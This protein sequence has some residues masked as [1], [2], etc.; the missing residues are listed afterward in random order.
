MTSWDSH[1]QIVHLQDQGKSN[2]VELP[3][4]HDVHPF[5]QYRENPGL[6]SDYPHNPPYES[7]DE[8]SLATETSTS[9]SSESLSDLSTPTTSSFQT[10]HSHP[11]GHLTNTWAANQINQFQQQRLPNANNDAPA[12]F[13]IKAAVCQHHLRYSDHLPW[14]QTELN[15]ERRYCDDCLERERLA[16]GIAALDLND[17]LSFLE[18]EQMGIGSQSP[19]PCMDP[20]PSR[21]GMLQETPPTLQSSQL[22]NPS[23][24]SIDQHSEPADEDMDDDFG[25]APTP[26]RRYKD[27]DLSHNYIPQQHLSKRVPKVRPW[28]EEPAFSDEY[29]WARFSEY[30]EMLLHGCL[31]HAQEPHDFPSDEP[32]SVP[33]QPSGFD[34]DKD[35]EDMEDPYDDPPSPEIGVSF[36]PEHLWV[37]ENIAREEEMAK[38]SA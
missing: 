18:V 14:S 9:A 34:D 35:D 4:T 28:D 16:K 12:Q 7:A 10:F 17:D 32:E 23:P 19:N 38:G 29:F 3:M 15:F 33:E 2:T 1:L 25:F 21:I 5:A 31:D 6:L 30:P 24:T 27:Q 37:G 22:D 13:S 26:A 36:S 20:D 11:P 8:Q